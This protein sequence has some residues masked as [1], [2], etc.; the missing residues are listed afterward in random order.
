MT[1][2]TCGDRRVGMTFGAAMMRDIAARRSSPSR[3]A[4]ITAKVRIFIPRGPEQVFDYFADLRHE[5]EY[6][7]QVSGIH[8]TSPG[9][10]GR[11]TTFE[12]FH[13]GLGRVSW[14]L[15]E[16]ERPVHVVI[17]GGV[18]QGGYRWTSDFEARDGGTWMTGQMEWVPPERWQILRPLLW[19]I[20]RFNAHR[21]FRRMSQVLQQRSRVPIGPDP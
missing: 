5:P 14:Q 3:M 15:S 20:L 18:G 21:S 4:P 10:I 12:G 17:E 9:P 7:G 1:F 16:Y 19:A 6:N 11:D 8:K 2:G 13:L